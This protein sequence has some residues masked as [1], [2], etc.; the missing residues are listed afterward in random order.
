MPG[1][2]P[3]DRGARGRAD[4]GGTV[5]GGIGVW[6]SG[7]PA[8]DGAAWG[9]AGGGG[10]GGGSGVRGWSP[11]MLG[12]ARRGAAAGQRAETRRGALPRRQKSNGRC[13]RCPAR[14]GG[15]RRGRAWQTLPATTRILNSRSFN[16]TAS[17]DVASN[18]W[19]ALAHGRR[20]R[21]HGRRA[22]DRA[23]APRVDLR[24]GKAP[25]RLLLA[26]S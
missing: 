4:G 3:P 5:D 25:W 20:R 2:S 11:G 16:E 14:R 17:Y 21:R 12:R 8:R 23:L 10:D 7:M 24:A 6:H 13:R 9:R 22:A 18:I 19:Q 15:A 1:S 26:T